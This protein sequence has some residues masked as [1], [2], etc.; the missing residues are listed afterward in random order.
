MQ[1]KD[2][3][4]DALM[5]MEIRDLSKDTHLNGGGVTDELFPLPIPSRN[6]PV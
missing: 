3:H 2:A 4:A 6:F 1:I 5:L